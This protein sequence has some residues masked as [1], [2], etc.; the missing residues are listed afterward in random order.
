MLRTVKVG[1]AAHYPGFAVVEL[2]GQGGVG[3][4]DRDGLVSV[5][6]AKRHFL[7]RPGFS[8]DIDPTERWSHVSTEE[9]SA[10]GS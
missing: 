6:P 5:D 7:N 10:R 3:H 9:A 4:V 2:D 1:G 8:G